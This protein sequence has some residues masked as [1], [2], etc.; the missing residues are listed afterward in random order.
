MGGA[1]NAAGRRFSIR[2][3]I[4]GKA[5]RQEV[6]C[7]RQARARRSTRDSSR[8]L[9][10][11]W[12]YTEHD[13]RKL[14]PDRHAWMAVPIVVPRGAPSPWCT[15]TPRPAVLH[16]RGTGPDSR[17]LR[18]HQRLHPG[19]IPMKQR[20]E[21]ACLGCDLSRE[22]P[23][24]SISR[25]GAVISGAGD[26]RGGSRRARRRRPDDHP[27]HKPAWLSRPRAGMPVPGDHERPAPRLEAR[28]VLLSGA[29]RY[30]SSAGERRGGTPRPRRPR[31]AAGASGS[32]APWPRPACGCACGA[33]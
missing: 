29:S 10:R 8:E 33:G 3:G 5:A 22:S 6:R 18:R 32:R 7:R 23:E 13:A 24:G 26:D 9:V 4:I 12:A 25:P 19:G 27:A 17:R 31:G 1:G 16:R 14:S 2:S 20:E 30:R 21:R 11:D 28:A 15:W